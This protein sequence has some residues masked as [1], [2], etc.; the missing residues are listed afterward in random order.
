[1]AEINIIKAGEGRVE[2]GIC[3]GVERSLGI[4]RHSR[5][6]STSLSVSSS[7]VRS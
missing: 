5:I 3:A 7:F 2:E 6:R 1:M 4:E